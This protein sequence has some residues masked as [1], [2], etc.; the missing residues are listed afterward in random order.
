MLARLFALLSLFGLSYAISCNSV[1][2]QDEV[3]SMTK[4]T[5]VCLPYGQSASSKV[6]CDGN[7]AQVHMF[8]NN[9]DCSGSPTT[10]GLC[11]AFARRSSSTCSATS[12]CNSSP[13]QYALGEM[14]AGVTGCDGDAP[15]D[16][17]SYSADAYIV[18]ACELGY[19]GTTVKTSC[20]NGALTQIEYTSTD[21]SGESLYSYTMSAMC[22]VEYGYALHYTCDLVAP[23]STT[24]T[25][26]PTYGND[27]EGEPTGRPTPEPTTAQPTWEP[28]TPEPTPEPTTAE[29]TTVDPTVDPTTGAPTG[30]TVNPTTA[31]PTSATI[32]PT[33]A[34]PTTAEPT[35]APVEGD[36]TQNP[37][38]SG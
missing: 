19:N 6:V 5:N 25:P 35:T 22:N 2:I 9:L 18:G 31:A 10:L 12:I 20:T 8:E 36:D 26:Q 13:C 24:A 14:W 29:P 32:N 30:V 17:T 37:G 16:H 15:E 28:T 27:P 23:G 11:D 34:A 3:G 38:S 33:T 1:S 4:P 7:T 21:C